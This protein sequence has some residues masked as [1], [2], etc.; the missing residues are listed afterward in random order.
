[1]DWDAEGEID[2]RI[3][4]RDDGA[5]VLPPR[6]YVDPRAIGPALYRVR[7]SFGFTLD[8]TYNLEGVATIDP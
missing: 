2:A 1:L 3:A 7:P 4:Y 5:I 6:Q 8:V